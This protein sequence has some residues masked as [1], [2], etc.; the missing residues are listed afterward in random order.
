MKLW[1]M[2]V[3]LSVILC[4]MLSGAV[5]LAA[6]IRVADQTVT[7]SDGE[8]EITVDDSESAQ[9]VDSGSG[10][11][12]LAIGNS[13]T[14]DSMNYVYRIAESAGLD[15][16]VGILWKGSQALHNQL[17]FIS[18]DEPVYT[19]E[20]YS[21]ETGAEGQIIEN[22]VAE[23]VFRDK[24]WDRVFLQQT[25]YGS[26]APASFYD[27]NGNSYI[28]QMTSVIRQKSGR[29]DLRF[30]WLMG[31]AYAGNYQSYR[32][33]MFDKN[34]KLMYSEIISTLK[35]TVLASG[36]IS[37]V[38]PVGTAIQNLRESYI[39]DHVNRDGR[40]LSY[41]M[42]RYE[43]AMTVVAALGGD[44]SRVTYIPDGENEFSEK[45]LP[46][47]RQAALDA[48]RTPYSIT[49][50][51]YKTSPSVPKVSLNG[52]SN[53]TDGIHL[54]WSGGEGDSELI[55]QIERKNPS[56]KWRTI[57][58]LS[59]ASEY[60][61]SV[62]EQG[63]EYSYRVTAKYDRYLK[64]VSSADTVMRLKTPEIKKL[65]SKTKKT[66]DIR[67]S[68]RTGTKK[69]Q[70]RYIKKSKTDSGSEWSSRESK[71]NTVTL[72]KLKSGETYLVQAR[73][74][75][76]DDGEVWYSAWSDVGECRVK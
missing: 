2:C 38:L 65:S 35:N 14:K 69:Y 45:H 20:L 59:G 62:A 44:I 41:D 51:S 17:D 74:K 49:A 71:S 67:I 33:K 16:T 60:T 75:A 42:G 37:Q 32:F 21:D 25:S 3:A 28:N 27:E 12:I 13:F 70:I 54:T 68:M 52:V 22:A 40:H 4:M 56:G 76:S 5:A 64:S 50:S 7:V 8:Q 31:W 48:V 46:M 34:Q 11:T 53:E 18:D 9:T 15:V 23:Q 39:G 72:K 36:E 30:G 24:H 66:M 58:E 26:A 47:L 57:A 29:S 55:Y 43:A 63:T 1:R 61:D 6:D 10:L 19:Y 73:C